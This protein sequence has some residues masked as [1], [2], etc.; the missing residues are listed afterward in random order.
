MGLAGAAALAERWPVA[1]PVIVRSGYT[2]VEATPLVFQGVA[3]GGLNVFRSD[4]ADFHDR[5]AECRALA[6]AVTLV[7]VSGQLSAE[8]VAEG[9]RAAL[10][11]RAVVEQAKG[12]L[13]HARSLG[14]PAAYDELVR[15]AEAE[16]LPLGIAA[17]RVMEQART[18]TLG[19]G[20]ATP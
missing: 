13:A 19:R 6:D 9:L 17:R 2:A 20:S 5:R 8:H 18:G 10:E 11:D 16:G 12:A 15:L 3:F 14:M 1:G 4:A 7:I